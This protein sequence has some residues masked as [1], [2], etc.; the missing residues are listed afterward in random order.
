MRAR[1]GKLQVGGCTAWMED[2]AGG[3]GHDGCNLRSNRD[4]GLV[5]TSASRQSVEAIYSA[6]LF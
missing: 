2:N 4:L 5:V 3:L 1:T 6:K